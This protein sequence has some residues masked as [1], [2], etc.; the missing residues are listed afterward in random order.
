MPND[1]ASKK[2]YRVVGFWDDPADLA[3]MMLSGSRPIPLAA[4]VPDAADTA[5]Q[6]PSEFFV[7]WSV[8]V[9]ASSAE[10]ALRLAPASVPVDEDGTTDRS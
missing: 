5:F 7:G 2:T 1:D 10:E 8:Q 9:E 6:D 4:F 3:D